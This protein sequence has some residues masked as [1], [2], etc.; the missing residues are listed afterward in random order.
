MSFAGITKAMVQHTSNIEDIPNK[1]LST[2]V[3]WPPHVKPLNVA[4]VNNPGLR[5]R[6]IVA[7]V[8]HPHP[9]FGGD[10]QNN[11]VDGVCNMLSNN[12]YLTYKDE[13]GKRD[14]LYNVSH[15]D[16][17]VQ[18]QDLVVMKG[19]DGQKEYVSKMFGP[20]TNHTLGD[21]NDCLDMIDAVNLPDETPATRPEKNKNTGIISVRYNS[22]GVADSDGAS[23]W[24]GSQT[25]V[26]DF[27]TILAWILSPQSKLFPTD[28]F[29]LGYSF[30]SCIANTGLDHIFST[31]LYEKQQK[32]HFFQQQQLF[33][34]LIAS[35]RGVFSLSYP[36]GFVPRTIFAGQHLSHVRSLNHMLLHNNNSNVLT[37]QQNEYAQ[38]LAHI[39]KLRDLGEKARP[40]WFKMVNEKT[41]FNKS[42]FVL[43]QDDEFAAPQTLVNLLNTCDYP[44]DHA[45][46]GV[47]GS[48]EVVEADYNAAKQ[49]LFVLMKT[50]TGHFWAGYE[51]IVT[52]VCHQF[53]LSRLFTEYTINKGDENNSDNE[54]EKNKDQQ[55]QQITLQTSQFALDFPAKP[56]KDDNTR[57]YIYDMNIWVVVLT[58][59]LCI[60]KLIYGRYE[61]YSSSASLA[62]TTTTTTTLHADGKIE[63]INNDLQTPEIKPNQVVDDRKHLDLTA[64]APD[65]HKRINAE[66]PPTDNSQKDEL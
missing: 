9:K 46:G 55:Q 38:Y 59:L 42:V 19:E 3:H 17:H 28:L 36:C 20:L 60:G 6:R 29:I 41:Y 32:L 44:L 64:L 37:T 22:S 33:D 11:V 10:A 16:P 58:L 48:G 2:F 63:V 43:D 14:V 26:D 13:D 7:L 15:Y 4:P 47:S 57:V 62:T 12:M 39:Q 40:E 27:H 25:E 18:E 5:E 8:M 66:T 51:H 49:K 45:E 61:A 65:I 30:G 35:F 50:H 1:S 23:T 56:Y 21:L 52:L 54:D 24:T 31:F 34:R 53:I